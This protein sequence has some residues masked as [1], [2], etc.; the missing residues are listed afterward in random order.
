MN[1]YQRR[2]PAQVLADA[3]LITGLEVAAAGMWGADAHAADCTATRYGMRL[4]IR[5]AGIRA[6]V[7]PHTM[8]HTAM[9]RRRRFERGAK[10]ISAQCD[11]ICGADAAVRLLEYLDGEWTPNA[12]SK[13]RKAAGSPTSDPKTI[14]RQL[15]GAIEVLTD[16]CPE[17]ADIEQFAADRAEAAAQSEIV[18]LLKLGSLHAKNPDPDRRFVGVHRLDRQRPP[19]SGSTLPHPA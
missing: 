19:G 7:D 13:N 9:L 5:A 3:G 8:L 14:R 2:P 15:A 10:A 6:G 17:L 11:K 1:R 4:A 12:L 16:A 18:T